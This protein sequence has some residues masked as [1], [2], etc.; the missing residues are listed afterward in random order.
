MKRVL[1]SVSGIGHVAWQAVRLLPLLS[2]SA[3]DS[4]CHG[5]VSSDLAHNN[6]MEQL[7]LTALLCI[8]G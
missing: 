2:V 5:T 4:L 8:A 1:N 7:Y 6:A 3:T